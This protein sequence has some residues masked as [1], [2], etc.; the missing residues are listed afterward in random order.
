MHYGPLFVW[1][2]GP[3]QKKHCAERWS[4]R[5]VRSKIMIMSTC[6]HAHIHYVICNVAGGDQIQLLDPSENKHLYYVLRWTCRTEFS[7]HVAD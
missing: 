5:C 3:L 2:T 1:R 4:K 7:F 6:Y